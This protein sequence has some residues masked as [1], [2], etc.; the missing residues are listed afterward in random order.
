MVFDT[1]ARRRAAHAIDD[2]LLP[3]ITRFLKCFCT[4]AI[5][6]WRMPCRRDFCSCIRKP[7]FAEEAHISTTLSPQEILGHDITC[8]LLELR[9]EA[10]YSLL[11]AVEAHATTPHAEDILL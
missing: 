2:R 4:V 11:R 9:F 6:R 1:M 7:A 5:S 10:A 3:A 8:R